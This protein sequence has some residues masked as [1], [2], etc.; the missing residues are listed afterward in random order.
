MPNTKLDRGFTST[1]G[2]PV[3]RSFAEKLAAATNEDKQ[4]NPIY[5]QAISKG[6]KKENAS[7]DADHPVYSGY[8]DGLFEC[9]YYG[10][11][12]DVPF[13]LQLECKQDVDLND[14]EQFAK[15]MLQVFYYIKQFQVSNVSKPKVIVL[16]TKINCLTIAT[17]SF[18][19]KYIESQNYPF[20]D[21]YGNKISASTAPFSPLNQPLLR[22]I[23]DD[24]DLQT[25]YRVIEVT[26]KNAVSELCKDI[27]KLAKDIGLKEDIDVSTLVR[28]FDFF[29]MKVLSDKSRK[30][31]GTREKVAA[32]MQVIL[33]P[34]LVNE[35][36]TVDVLGN[37][38]HSDTYDF[39]GVSITVD[40]NKF[41]SF[42]NLFYLH[43]RQLAEAK[44]L[45]A[46]QDQLIEDLDRRRKGD[47]YTPSIWVDEAH[48]LMDKNLGPN[49]RK[50][51]IVWDCAWGTGNLTRD[52]NDFQHLYCSTL[53]EEDIKTGQKYNPFNAK[54]QYDFL[55]DD[56][57]LFQ[58]AEDTLWSPF[59]GTRFYKSDL[60]KDKVNFKDIADIYAQAVEAGVTTEEKCQQAMQKAVELLHQSKLH[61]M[62]RSSTASKSLI[63]ELLE[64]SQAGENGRPL[65]FFINPPYATTGN[66]D[67]KGNKD[68]GLAD[69]CVN[70]LMQDAGSCRQHKRHS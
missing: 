56:V 50:E 38:T 57:S 17:D 26:D 46:V 16:G 60:I 33:N 27:V 52:Y 10:E 21:E 5:V 59:I 4:V 39:N 63:D 6:L 42:R 29:D 22:R 12:G 51:S 19:S 64:S 36:V 55:N 20:T 31:L 49:W 40:P 34:T 13:L 28:A 54:F 65:V 68:G 3:N 37:R 8:T 66:I 1:G 69:T 67:M 30:S 25:K 23:R 62:G 2:K 35:T 45:T 14:S 18:Y 41:N 15:V 7:M 53:Y 44:S 48:K 58:I 24:A 47:F 11:N 43:T 9:S 70:D 61:L 32:F